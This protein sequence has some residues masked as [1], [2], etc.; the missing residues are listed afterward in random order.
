M[1]DL[2]TRE[3]GVGAESDS[4]EDMSIDG[5]RCSDGSSFF[6]NKGR[7]NSTIK[8]NRE[9]SV[10]VCSNDFEESFD[11]QDLK[12]SPADKPGGFGRAAKVD[13]QHKQGPATLDNN[14]NTHKRECR[15]KDDDNTKKP[16]VQINQLT[17][18][19]KVPT[20]DNH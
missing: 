9:E 12:M 5:I 6:D 8:Y 17:I 16:Q 1:L 4:E 13:D 10:S 3:E 11:E 15:K 20:K 7:G 19:I 18:T 14:D 2:Q